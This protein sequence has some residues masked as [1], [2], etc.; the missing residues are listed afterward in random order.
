MI[1]KK[2]KEGDVTIYTVDKDYDDEK[3]RGKISTFIKRDHIKN[4]IDHDADV[5]TAD[6]KLLIRFRKGVLPTTHTKLFYD[7]IIKFAKNIL[8]V[9]SSFSDLVKAYKLY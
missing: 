1:I 8:T 5:Y 9:N 6:G 7:N 3:L 4:I 2:E